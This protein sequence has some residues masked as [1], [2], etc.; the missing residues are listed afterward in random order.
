MASDA[1]EAIIE[2]R[3]SRRIL[4][5][6]GALAPATVEAGYAVQKEIALRLGGLPPAG[7]KIGATTTQMQV[8]TPPISCAVFQP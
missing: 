4:A 1:A 7:F 3:R 6:L 5:P 8:V 2:A